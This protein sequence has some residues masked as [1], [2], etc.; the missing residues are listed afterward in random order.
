M[1]KITL[2]A[3]IRKPGGGYAF[4]R[5]E[6]ARRGKPV[7]PKEPTGATC[8]YF[9]YTDNGKQ[10]MKPAGDSFQDAVL[11]L[12]SKE[13]EIEC[14]KRGLPVQKVA[15]D[16][17]TIAEA[18]EQF[19]KNQAALDKAPSTVYGY[20]RAVRQ[21]R[22]SCSKVYVDEITQQDILD[23]MAWLR[24]NLP[25]RSHGQQ[26]GT[27]R[28]RLS[29]LS[30][31]FLHYGMKNPWPKKQWPKVEE[32]RVEAYTGEQVQ[33]LLS[34][35]TP[36]EYD[37][38]LFLVCTGFRDDEVA[39]AVYSDVN[40]KAHEIKTGPKP[41]MG[42]TTK[43]GK[44]RSVRVPAELI[45]RLKDRRGREPESALVFPNSN[46][47]PDSAL[48]QRVR[49]AAERSNFVGRVTLHKFRKTFGTRY[50]EKH[51]IVNAQHLLGHADIR[52][53]Q[54]YL[55]ETKIARSA[56]EALFEDLVGK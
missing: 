40:F 14:I 46:G 4:S 13:V 8:Y 12:R 19:I 9:R 23:H 16:R 32:R 25:A 47:R 43:N 31:F 35:A 1:R 53:T 56:V 10:V 28:T 11:M 50:G 26:N 6:T 15:E 39:H 45:E 27:I 7:A 17:R 30:V 20:T 5:V 51:G 29:Y 18:A 48:L 37:L 2:M 42:F 36:D 55:A 34:K 38:I 22:E 52:T 41:E 21:F 49:R 44:E 24:K 33:I 54:K 3:R